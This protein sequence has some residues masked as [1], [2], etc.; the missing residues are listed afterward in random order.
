[1]LKSVL[2]EKDDFCIPN[3]ILITAM[4]KYPIL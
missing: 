4:S 3:Q 1:M 2:K